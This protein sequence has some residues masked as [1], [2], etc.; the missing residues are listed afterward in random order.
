[1]MGGRVRT[2][3]LGHGWTQVEAAARAGMSLASYKRFEQSGA[4]A[5]V[6]LLRIAIA[7]DQLGGI[8]GLFLPPPLGSLD[9]L[10]KPAKVRRRAPRRVKS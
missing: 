3:R 6:S 8:D 9:E 5:F 1:M 2:L 4:V 10:A 7:F